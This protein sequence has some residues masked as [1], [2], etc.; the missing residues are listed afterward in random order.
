[1]SSLPIGGFM[2]IPLAM[3]IPFMAAQS[4]IMGDAF[5][6]GYQFGKR[7]ISAM[8]NE[9]FNSLTQSDLI[10][11]MQQ[12]FKKAIPTIQQTL[13]D[14][15][16]LQTTIIEEMIKIV[17]EFLK[18]LTGLGGKAVDI[19]GAPAV[20]SKTEVETTIGRT[21]TSRPSTASKAVTAAQQLQA[22]IKRQDQDRADFLYNDFRAKEKAY[23]AS[24]KFRN[25]EKRSTSGSAIDLAHKQKLYQAAAKKYTDYMQLFRERH[26]TNPKQNF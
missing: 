10:T 2:P 8:S 14:S 22:T 5:G 4:L 12:E 15:S 16:E 1:M 7:K 3:M 21:G 23:I 13:D 17:P 24:V 19:L 20:E 6:K 25:A 11:S 26:G 9:E 18:F